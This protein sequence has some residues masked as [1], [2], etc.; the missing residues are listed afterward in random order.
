MQGNKFDKP[1]RVF[2][3]IKKL[4]EG[5]T[6]NEGDIRELI[7]ELYYLPEIYFNKNEFFFG[8]DEN[9]ELVKDVK[10][11]YNDN[12]NDKDSILKYEYI[13]SLKNKLESKKKLED[14]I[15]L[16][17]GTKQKKY[18]Y[19]NKNI[20]YYEKYHY[21]NLKID[22]QKKQQQI[23]KDSPV[24][25][26]ANIIYNDLVRCEF[27]LVPNQI[28]DDKL[29]EIK[30]KSIFFKK[31]KIFNLEKFELEH[32]SFES[33]NYL[34]KSFE[35]KSVDIINGLY[36]Y[37][38]ENTSFEPESKKK[39]NNLINEYHKMFLNYVKGTSNFKVKDTSICFEGNN[40]G[41]I[42]ITIK[43]TEQKTIKLRDH[44]RI[45]KYIDYNKRLNMFLSYSLDGFI[46]LY[47][48]PKCKFVR[49]IKVSNFFENELKEVILISNP[50]PMIFAYD[51]D[52]MFT[53]S[54]NGDLI[55]S[56]NINSLIKEIYDIV[57][58]SIKDIDINICVDKDF[59]IMKDFICMKKYLNKEKIEFV[60]FEVGLPS[61][62]VL[63]KEKSKKEDIY[64]RYTCSI[65]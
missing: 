23:T 12:D 19:D 52:S 18:M 1:D 56:I 16:I 21:N 55:K 20:N 8:K 38:M 50:F 22:E 2:R 43:G 7:P 51:S 15:N 53:L 60:E 54:I 65:F 35:C 58:K 29:V 28:Y 63:K 30:D 64:M 31:I 39:I 33:F 48:F 10:V 25:D 9:G 49:A 14:W 61:F 37:I 32:Q 62:N 36:Y 13:T 17:F 27:G 40:I 24:S 59:G 45:I 42:K 41:D 5:N 11:T 26:E 4:I 44:N 6:K 34:Y 47:T 3:S 46:N 57:L